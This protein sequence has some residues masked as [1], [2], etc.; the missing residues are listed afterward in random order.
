MTNFK[1]VGLDRQNS[2]NGEDQDLTTIFEIPEFER[3]ILHEIEWTLY[4]QKTAYLWNV[5]ASIKRSLLDNF[6]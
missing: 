1:P 6:G 3:Y 4:I 2:L 5:L